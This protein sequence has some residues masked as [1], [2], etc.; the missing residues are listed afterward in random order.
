[1]QL[2]LANLLLDHDPLKA[3]IGKRIHWDVMGQGLALPFVVM[4][5]ISRVNNYHMAGRDGYVMSRIQFDCRGRTAAEAR[6]V[7]EAVSGRLSG[8]R[9]DF[10]GVRFLGCF[11]EGQRTRHDKDGNVIWFTDSRDFMIHWTE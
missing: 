5:A 2:V 9:G 10:A 4:F 1:M 8:F 11:E 6:S 3:L 7:A